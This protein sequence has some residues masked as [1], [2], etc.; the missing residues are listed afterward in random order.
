M[1]AFISDSIDEY[2]K[3]LRDM[4]V[5]HSR[6]PLPAASLLIIQDTTTSFDSDDMFRPT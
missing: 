1:I 2:N 3:M 5:L 4:L 6:L